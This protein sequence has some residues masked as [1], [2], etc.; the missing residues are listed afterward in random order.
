ML[1]QLNGNTQ[2]NHLR[3]EHRITAK[4][5]DVPAPITSFAEL[6]G[7]VRAYLLRNIHAAGYTVPTPVQMQ[8]IPILLRERELMAVAPTGM[9]SPCLC[10][11]K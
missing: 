11:W 6:E 2:V 4:G 1:V 5:G 8:A 9:S 10:A 3:R 7:S